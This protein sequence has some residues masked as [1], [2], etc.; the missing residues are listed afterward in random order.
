M[1]VRDC[2]CEA[3]VGCVEVLVVPRG[4]LWW[5]EMDGNAAGGCIC[6]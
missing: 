3:C 6:V 4:V 2:G 1:D 5:S